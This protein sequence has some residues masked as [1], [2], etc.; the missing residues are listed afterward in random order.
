MSTS[1]GGDVF[2]PLQKTN[3]Y[4][5][6][7]VSLSCEADVCVCKQ[8]S[9][10]FVQARMAVTYPNLRMEERAYNHNALAELPRAVENEHTDILALSL[11]GCLPIS[12]EVEEVLKSVRTSIFLFRDKDAVVPSHGT[13][14]SVVDADEVAAAESGQRYTRPSRNGG[15]R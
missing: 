15:P 8:A 11:A 14:F 4:G 3:A 9:R 2:V 7:L 10:V 6:D 12:K 5:G 13:G 1:Q